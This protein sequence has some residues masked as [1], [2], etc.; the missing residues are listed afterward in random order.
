MTNIVGLLLF[1]G[2]FWYLYFIVTYLYINYKTEHL[3]TDL[4][5]DYHGIGRSFEAF[6]PALV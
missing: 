1:N 2:L 3:N 4:E 5:V 6:G